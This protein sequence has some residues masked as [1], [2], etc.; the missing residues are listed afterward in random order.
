MRG[1]PG[2]RTLKNW[3]A[4]QQLS[5]FAC[6]RWTTAGV[7]DKS[8]AQNAGGGSILEVRSGP[9][10][11][12][13]PGGH[14]GLPVRVSGG[15]KGVRGMLFAFFSEVELG[16]TQQVSSSRLHFQVSGFRSQGSALRFQVSAFKL[17]I[18]DDR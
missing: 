18:T 7:L 16:A 1:K 11:L 2:G 13:P 6:V 15:S 8:G 10:H 9:G 17:Q 14:Q 12:G 3:T 5:K 4:A